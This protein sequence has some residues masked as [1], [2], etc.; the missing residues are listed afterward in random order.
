MVDKD[1]YGKR[2]SFGFGHLNFSV[3]QIDKRATMDLTDFIREAGQGRLV[4]VIRASSAND[5]L[6]RSERVLDAGVGLLEIALD[7][8]MR[9]R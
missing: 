8:R 6:E 9:C 1:W 2:V 7:R 5:G 4:A 3:V